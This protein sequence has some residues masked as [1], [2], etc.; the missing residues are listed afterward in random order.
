MLKQ[1]RIR[2]M[3]EYI[4]QKGFV[5]LDE[6]CRKFSISINTARSDV[7]EIINTGRAQKTYGGVSA[8]P[9]ANYASYEIREEEHSAIKQSIAHTAAQF[10]DDGDIIYI[11]VGTTCLPIVDYIPAE[12]KITIITN[13]LAVISKAARRPNT[14][15]MTMGGTYQSHSN[16]FKCTYPAMHSY[17]DS[18]NITK[19]FLGTTGVSPR[20]MLTNSENFGREVRS[21]LLQRC[22]ECYLLA[23]ATKFGRAAL[24]SYG[25]LRDLAA[26]ITDRGLSEKYRKL[27]HDVGVRLIMA[28]QPK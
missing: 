13:D 12:Y 25:S 1:E 3:D 17:I 14:K 22:P 4:S 19:A 26:C 28:D 18:C 9:V 8:L 7:R 15:L 24:L 27:C 11:D 20:G 6:L 16:S 2:L 10:V 5:S 23:D 21:L